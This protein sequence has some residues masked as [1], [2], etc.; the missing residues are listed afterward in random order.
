[1]NSVTITV[2]SLAIV[3]MV[4]TVTAAYISEND[5]L[6]EDYDEGLSE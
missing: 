2:A 5:I 6:R 3:L 4:N 1:M